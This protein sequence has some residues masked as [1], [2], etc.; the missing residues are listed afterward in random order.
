MI[1]IHLVAVLI[2]LQLHL[3]VSVMM[4][5]LVGLEGFKLTIWGRAGEVRSKFRRAPQ[6]WQEP[7]DGSSTQ[8]VVGSA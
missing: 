2:S 1:H 7:V 6:R 8:A 5:L 4:V 3:L